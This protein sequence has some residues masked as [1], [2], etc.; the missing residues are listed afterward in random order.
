MDL[1]VVESRS[2]E[3][4][5]ESLGQHNLQYVVLTDAQTPIMAELQAA[6]S[7]H[8]TKPDAELDIPD[9]GYCPLPFTPIPEVLWDLHTPPLAGCEVSV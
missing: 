5:S 6:E 7:A 2:L 8:N 9:A 4:S 3:T 1:S